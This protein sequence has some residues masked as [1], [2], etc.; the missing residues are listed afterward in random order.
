[1]LPSLAAKLTVT[2]SPLG[3]VIVWLTAPPVRLTATAKVPSSV[4]SSIPTISALPLALRAYTAGV[5]PV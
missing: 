4:S 3:K 5:V 1:M 2:S